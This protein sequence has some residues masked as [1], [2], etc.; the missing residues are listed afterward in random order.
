MSIFYGSGLIVL[1]IQIACAWHVYRTGR[2]MLWILPIIF[3]PLLG[4]G[5]YVLFEILPEYVNGATARR[6]ADNVTSV[7]DPGRAYREKKRQVA[8][9]GSAQAKRELADECIKRGRFQDAI[10]LYESAMAAGFADD[11]AFLHGL[12]RAKL[13]AGEGAAAQAL[14]E[15]LKEADPAAFYADA[16]LDYARSMEL[17]GKDAEALAQYEKVVPTYPGEEARCRYG[18]L[19]KKLGQNDRAKAVFREIVESVRGAPAFYRRS[20]REWA[21][22]ARSNL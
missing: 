4:C 10:E 17:Q 20:Q 16:E 9:V 6:F 7:A 19:L 21:S 14:F 8:L 11:P 3:V 12:A 5:F 13:L 2:P 15:K 18:L 22:I 1:L